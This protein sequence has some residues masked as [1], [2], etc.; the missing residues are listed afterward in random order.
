MPAVDAMACAARGLS[1]VVGALVF[2]GVFVGRPLA[3]TTFR[4][5]PAWYDQLEANSASPLPLPSTR[6]RVQ[7]II[8]P[9]RLAPQG[10]AVDAIALRPEND[11]VSSQSAFTV[12]NVTLE[13][14]QT[15]RPLAQLG[16]RFA[17]QRGS[18][19]QVF[20]GDLSLP[21]VR[22]VPGATAAFAVRIPFSLR[23]AFPTGAGRRLV[24]EWRVR[25]SLGGS[26]GYSFDAAST[27]GNVRRYGRTG[28]LPYFDR[29]LLLGEASAPSGG[30]FVRLVPRGSVELINQA[31]IQ[32][33]GGVTLFAAARRDPGLDLAPFGAP[34]Q[35]LFVDQVVASQPFQMGGTRAGY[36]ATLSLSVP[37]DPAWT[38]RRF[39]A[40]SVIGFPGFNALG[41]V[42]TNGLEVTV[43]AALPSSRVLL[44]E[45][46]DAGDGRL[47]VHD[48]P[49][50]QFEGQFF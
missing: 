4:T 39:F 34:L 8:D 14:G 5:V 10:L 9:S 49:V 25:D 42:T 13:F 1:L 29:V 43:G 45:D 2:V 28:Q 12:R 16:T 50:V 48:A 15:T 19:A 32:P 22:S 36:G 26:P 41:V 21:A 35:E 30:R 23:Q 7:Q 40:Q 31:F 47:D 37:N 11:L 24:L 44:A 33:L 46:P 38:G 6:A 17:D 18:V 3:Q 20:Q 27:G